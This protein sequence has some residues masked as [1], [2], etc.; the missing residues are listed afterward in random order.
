[1]LNEL[2][3]LA[4]DLEV[5]AAPR[6][7]RAAEQPETIRPFSEISQWVRNWTLASWGV[8]TVVVL[9]AFGGKLDVLFILGVVLAFGGMFFGTPIVL[10]RIKSAERPVKPKIY[11]DTP[12]GRMTQTEVM[13]Q[14]VM[15]PLILSVGMAVI[16]YFA[17]HG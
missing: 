1:M 6:I 11:V 12:N 15:V 8:F 14:I 17:T 13:L 16:G 4:H 10:A 3:T 9:A 7:D 5:E 2:D